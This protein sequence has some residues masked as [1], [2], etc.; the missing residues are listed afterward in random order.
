MP[1]I[2]VRD[3]PWQELPRARRAALGVIAAL[4]SELGADAAGALVRWAAAGARPLAAGLVAARVLEAEE[5]PRGAAAVALRGPDGTSATLALDHRTL[6]AVL[7]LLSGAEPP[8][9]VAAGALERGLVI[10]AVASLLSELG[11][12][13]AW[14][15]D[16]SEPEGGAGRVLVE[17][18]LALGAARGLAWLGLDATSLARLRARARPTP[19]TLERTSRLAGL[20]LRCAVE[21]GRLSL[22]TAELASLGPGDLLVSPEC[23]REAESHPCLLRVGAGGF[24][25][26]ATVGAAGS[27]RIE[28]PYRRGGLGMTSESAKRG[29]L[30]DDLQVELTVELGRLTLSAAQVLALEPGDV[31]A[32]SRPLRAAVELRVGDRPVARG[33]LCD[34]EGEAGVRLLEVF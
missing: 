15:V 21:L 11:A 27:L 1:E 22:T 7:G 16:V 13:C 34:V 25:G 32:L 31:L 5:G 29:E 26:L 23:P 8:V 17:A 3:Y 10:Y 19:E 2:A 4:R 18:E 30:A 33:E 6:G 14:S 20:R 12:A 9:V 24:P 28:E